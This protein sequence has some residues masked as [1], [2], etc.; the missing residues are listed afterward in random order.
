MSE[1]FSSGI[2]KIKTNTSQ[3]NKKYYIPIVL[4]TL[5]HTHCFKELNNA[6]AF[7][8]FY[9]NTII[10]TIQIKTKIIFVKENY[11]DEYF[12]H[13]IMMLMKIAVFKTCH[14]TVNEQWSF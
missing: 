1:Q 10:E 4:H 13:Q 9:I 6:F 11:K 12:V 7:I 3:T 14:R 2:K 5:K 8:F